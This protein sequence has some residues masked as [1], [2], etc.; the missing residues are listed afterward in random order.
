[1]PPKKQSKKYLRK[2]LLKATILG[3]LCCLIWYGWEYTKPVN[4][5]IKN[6]KIFATYDHVEQKPLQKIVSSYLDNG[7]FYLNVIGLKQQLLKLPWVYAVSIQRQWP[8][9]VTINVAEQH[10]ILQWGT[11]AL[12]NPEGTVFTPPPSSF[13]KDLPIIFGPQEKEPE[14]F[15]LYQKMLLTL[16]PL[17]LVIKQL[18][19]KSHHH[20]EIILNNN[21]IVYLKEAEPITQLELLA[22]LYRKVTAEHDKPPKSIDLRYQS[23]LAIKWD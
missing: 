12:I 10:P 8:D 18:V 15:A 21:T 9:T 7:F 23:G 11:K 4:F 17:D 16:E 13:P 22:S 6:V 3:A 5:P 14:I 2:L 1:M 20:W 19:L